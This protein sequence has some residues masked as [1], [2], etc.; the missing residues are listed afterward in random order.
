VLVNSSSASASE[1]VAGALQDH[2][3]ALILGRQTF[4]KGSVQTVVEL[5]KEMGLKLTIA[6]YYTPSG[7]SIQEKGVTP[8]VVLDDYDT[9]LLA[10]AKRKT[11]SMREADLK[12]H[13]L[14]EEG[15]N[16]LA[17]GKEFD[18]EELQGLTKS[19][20][21]KDSGR[22][23]ASGRKKKDS[24]EAMDLDDGD[25]AWGP[26]RFNAKE[27]YQTKEALNYLRSF[28]FY[29]KMNDKKATL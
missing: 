26:A 25:E 28:E 6:R 23:E 16:E 8:D 20:S 21:T 10:Q 12:G 19:N 13:M 1:I 29:K 3:R 24:R 18:L 15:S 27:D 22:G 4:G 11:E 17:G 9:K 14:N 2:K 5:G 7:K